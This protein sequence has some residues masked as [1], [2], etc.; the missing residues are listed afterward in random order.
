VV[1]LGVLSGAGNLANAKPNSVSASRSADGTLPGIAPS[2]TELPRLKRLWFV[3]NVF[4]AAVNG[5]AVAPNGLFVVRDELTNELVALET[6]TG[7]A[8]W[9]AKRDADL[10]VVN[11]VS[12]HVLVFSLR[13]NAL[14]SYAADTGTLEWTN[15]GACSGLYQV[16][17]LRMAGDGNTAVG[18]CALLPFGPQPPLGEETFTD[19]KTYLLGLDLDSGHELWRRP[20]SGRVHRLACDGKMAAH[21]TWPQESGR[22]M[23]ETVTYLDARTGATRWKASIQNHLMAL[24]LAPGLVVAVGTKLQ[25]LNARNGRTKWALDLYKDPREVGKL[26]ADVFAPGFAPDILDDLLLWPLEDG[27]LVG[28]V[29]ATGK[30]RRR[31][32]FTGP[33]RSDRISALQVVRKRILVLLDDY[34]WRRTIVILEKDRTRTMATPRTSNAV[35]LPQDLLISDAETGLAGFSLRENDSDPAERDLGP[36]ERVNA[37]LDRMDESSTTGKFMAP[38]EVDELEVIPGYVERLLAIAK[39]RTAGRRE[40]AVVMIGQLKISAGI[41]VL[42][43]ILSEQIPPEPGAP[44]PEE[45]KSKPKSP[46]EFRAYRGQWEQA[47]AYRPPLDYWERLYAHRKAVS[48]REAVLKAKA[49]LEG[50]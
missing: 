9:R 14:S 18:L 8:R 11:V 21:A 3:P 19:A 47:I 36:I 13:T 33:A 42:N 26:P 7:R 10:F 6:E 37:L 41:P 39:D 28:Y 27:T 30:E 2:M 31:W 49:C 48:L 34:R 24:G 50:R 40:E 38:S 25:I 46:D 22:K 43:S 45:P 32:R 1:C 12:N 20:V 29:S 17:H 23:I 35:I 5:S 15:A 16:G 4:N 44:G